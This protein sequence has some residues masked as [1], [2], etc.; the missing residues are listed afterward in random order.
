MATCP[1]DPLIGPKLSHRRPRCQRA[2]QAKR[3]FLRLGVGE[4]RSP[5]SPGVG[6]GGFVRCCRVP[7]SA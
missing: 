2:Q 6:A 1:P 5:H 7:G 4:S 3:S